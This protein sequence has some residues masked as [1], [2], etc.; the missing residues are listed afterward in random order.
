MPSEAHDDSV[1]EEVDLSEMTYE[2]DDD[3]Y[4]Y[5]CPCGDMFE[6]TKDA[7]VSGETIAH[8]PSCSL[9]IRVL[10]PE[11]FGAKMQGSTPGK[12]EVEALV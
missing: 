1:Y 2:A 12:A 5:E 10:V 6:I 11:G 9:L 8:C 3:T 7:L 4:Y